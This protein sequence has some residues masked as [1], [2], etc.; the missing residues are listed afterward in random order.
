M[1]IIKNK[2]QLCEAFITAYKDFELVREYIDY[3]VITTAYTNN[4]LR[5]FIN[6]GTDINVVTTTYVD[7][8]LLNMC[9]AKWVWLNE[10]SKSECKDEALDQFCGFFT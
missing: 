8:M 5:G 10:K 2:D 9:I 7:L 1:R 4:L 3:T 6:P